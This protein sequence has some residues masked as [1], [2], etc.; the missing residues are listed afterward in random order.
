MRAEYGS[1]V[2]DRM[3]DAVGLLDC[4]RLGGSATP[5]AAD[6]AA[7]AAA[8]ATQVEFRK[9]SS[10]KANWSAGFRSPHSPLHL[11]SM[12]Y[13]RYD[14]MLRINAA[15]K[16][17][18]GW[19]IA[20]MTYFGTLVATIKDTAIN[21]KAVAAEFVATTLFIAIS[22]GAALG[23]AELVDAPPAVHAVGTAA[24]FG[25]TIVALA[26]G[27]GHTSGGQINPAV[28]IGLVASGNLP[29]LQGALN[30][31]GQVL[32][33]IAGSGI[34][35][36]MFP[37]DGH[38]TTLAANSVPDGLAVGRAFLGEMVGTFALVFV[39]LETACS[40]KSA[41]NRALAPIAIGYTV[42]VVHLLLIPYTS[43]SINPARSLGPAI[44][45]G[46]WGKHFWVFMVAP[47]TGGIVAA[48]VHM[49]LSGAFDETDTATGLMA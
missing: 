19:V 9:Q 35:Y 11:I 6:R 29:A 31:G 44:V 42:F 46:F 22:T 25:F 34:V 23:L 43:A 10:T 17:I 24:A 20:T 40:L 26:Y 16:Y 48:P 37:G 2:E 4:L 3:E 15:V 39:V 45:S 13:M 33:A 14:I 27:T 8:H 30:I 5:F 18:L 28:T 36:G 38:G 1:T 32:G 7:A 41:A 21:F 47:I 49:L 12:I